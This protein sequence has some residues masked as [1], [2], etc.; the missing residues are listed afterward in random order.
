MSLNPIKRIVDNLGS[1]CTAMTHIGFTTTVR[2]T[3][4]MALGG[5]LVTAIPA[6]I[7]ATGLLIGVVPIAL[8]LDRIAKPI[9]KS[10]NLLT[11]KNNQNFTLKH[12]VASWALMPLKFIATVPAAALIAI[13][14]AVASP[15]FLLAFVGGIAAGAGYCR[16]I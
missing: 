8:L 5:R 2:K 6:G 12:K 13:I 9:L 10:A 14:T 3:S 1:V 4:R 7:A 11:D 16:N 15:V